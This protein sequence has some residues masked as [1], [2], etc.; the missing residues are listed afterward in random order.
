[1]S[2][3]QAQRQAGRPARR[4][5]GVRRR[6]V[7][8]ADR[9]A[10]LRGR[11]GYRDAG[12]GDEG[13]QI[14]HDAPAA[15]RHLMRRCLERDPRLRL[16]DIG[17]ARNRLLEDYG[18]WL[19]PIAYRRLPSCRRTRHVVP[20]AWR[21]GDRCR[22]TRPA[23]PDGCSRTVPAAGV[24]IGK[25]TLAVDG[26]Q[27]GGA[28]RRRSRRTARSWCMPVVA[29]V[30]AVAARADRTLSRDLRARDGGGCAVFLLVAG[31]PSGWLPLRRSWLLENAR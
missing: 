22:D 6:A 13:Q 26:L 3:E 19:N 21:C 8:D 15:I 1:M 12:L 24:P 31:Q 2:P 7:R 11:D 9:D 4:H 14:I 30:K 29:V 23:S 28:R 17:E 27:I 10:G 16:R 5:L 18:W 25:F 20:G